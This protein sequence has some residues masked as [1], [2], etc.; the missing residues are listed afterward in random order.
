MRKLQWYPQ[1]GSAIISIDYARGRREFVV[2]SLQMLMLLAFNNRAAMTY[3]E[4]LALV[5]LPDDLDTHR[6]LLS[7]VHPSVGIVQKLPMSNKL[8]RTHKLRLAPDYQ[9]PSLR[10][11]VPLLNADQIAG[12]ERRDESDDSKQIE[13]AIELQRRYWSVVSFSARMNSQCFFCW[14]QHR[15]VDRS[16]YEITKDH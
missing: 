1:L 10:V 8:D 16:N 11:R 7:L 6:H 14:G 12:P 9:S 2:T 13:A 4:L 3:D 5:R 15:C